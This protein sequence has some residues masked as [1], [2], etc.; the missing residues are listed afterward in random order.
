MLALG[1]GLKAKIVGLL[2]VRGLRV[3]GLAN[4]VLGLVVPGLGLTPCSLVNI[5]DADQPHWQYASNKR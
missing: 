4:K 2:V 1:L 3:I 5:S